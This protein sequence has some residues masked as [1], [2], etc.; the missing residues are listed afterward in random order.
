VTIEPG[1]HPIAVHFPLALVVTAALLLVAARL[2]PQERHAKTLATVGTWNLCIGAV[3]ALFAL[4][5]GL[6]ALIGL[7]AGPAAHQAIFLHVK[8]AIFTS[9]ALLLV[10]VWRGAGAAQESRPAWLFIAILIAVTA[11]L[12][13]TGYQG[14]QNVYRYGVGVHSESKK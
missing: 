10:A 6:A 12:V 3:A 2:L 9:L 13:V 8:W 11:A 5:T 4:G 14:G 7:H 1:W